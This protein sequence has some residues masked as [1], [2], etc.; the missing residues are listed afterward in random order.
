MAK[1]CRHKIKG[2]L[3][4]AVTRD[5]PPLILDPVSGYP[6]LLSPT[7]S[8]FQKRKRG[9]QK[10]N[11]ALAGLED[12]NT[13]VI[14]SGIQIFLSTFSINHKLPIKPGYGE[15]KGG[16]NRSRTG[17]PWLRTKCPDH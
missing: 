12:Y 3:T 9:W 5:R 11:P 7:F 14:A 4:L 8:Q 17:V 13:T 6:L 1:N 2:G 15:V 16:P 10:Q